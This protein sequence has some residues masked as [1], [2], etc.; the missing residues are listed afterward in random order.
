MRERELGRIREK[1]R[2]GER[3]GGRK[4]EGQKDKRNYRKMKKVI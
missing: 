2:D 1:E 3:K 4:L